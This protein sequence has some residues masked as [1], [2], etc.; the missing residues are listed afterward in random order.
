[1]SE[2]ERIFS[3]RA[4]KAAKAISLLTNGMKYAPTQEE[5]D[6]TIAVLKEAVNDVAQLYGM[7]PGVKVEEVKEEPPKNSRLLFA[8]KSVSDDVAGIP[9]NMLTKY[10]T[11]IMAR[12]CN[13]F[14]DPTTP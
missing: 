9:E 12:M 5:K 3:P 6:A 4:E 14:E 11:H 1:M 10:V 13:K 7:L 8:F 2:F